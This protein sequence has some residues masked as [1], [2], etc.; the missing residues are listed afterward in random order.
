MDVFGSLGLG[1]WLSWQVQTH[2]DL[3]RL[4]TSLFLACALDS[5]LLSASEGRGWGG[6]KER[7]GVVRHSSTLML[8]AMKMLNIFSHIIDQKDPEEKEK[9]GSA[10]TF[11]PHVLHK[12]VHPVLAEEAD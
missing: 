4:A 12:R 1:S 6:G 5:L 11:I 8:H 2:T 10:R 7:E 3:L 9:V